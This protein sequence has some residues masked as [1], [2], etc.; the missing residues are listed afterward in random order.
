MH[1]YIRNEWFGIVSGQNPPVF[2]RV[3]VLLSVC[4]MVFG[5]R[6]LYYMEYVDKLHR[7]NRILKVTYGCQQHLVLTILVQKLSV[8]DISEKMDFSKWLLYCIQYLI[9]T[10]Q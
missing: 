1:I 9:K 2:D 8:L 6:F 3:T 4:K 10:S 7:L 5:L